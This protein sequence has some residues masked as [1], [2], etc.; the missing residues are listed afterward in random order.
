ML[1]I[2]DECC[3]ELCCLMDKVAQYTEITPPYKQIRP[4][5]TFHRPIVGIKQEVIE[6][7]I[8]SSVYCARQAMMQIGSLA[9]FGEQYIVLPVCPTF[10]L[11][12]FW[13]TL[14][15]LLLQ[16]PEYIHEEYDRCNTL[17]ITVAKKVSKVFDNDIWKAIKTI[18][19][20]NLV[21]PINR[22][23]LCRKRINGDNNQWEEI[24]TF[25]IHT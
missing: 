8:R 23:L 9:P 6:H 20:P 24:K 2:P 11:A 21:I 22:V 18:S 13:T 12:L 15:G 5:I 19:V 25:D 4:H 10:S 16:L 17:H 3:E 14:N 7:L 1:P